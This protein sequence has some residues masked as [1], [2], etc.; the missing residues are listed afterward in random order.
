MAP[1]LLFA[2]TYV[3]AWV[4]YNN[5]ITSICLTWFRYFQ[6]LPEL[7]LSLI[8]SQIVTLLHSTFVT[9]CNHPLGFLPAW[10][11]CLT[12]PSP[13]SRFQL[14]YS[15][16][17]S[18]AAAIFHLCDPCDPVLL[19]CDPLFVPPPRQQCLLMVHRG[20][21]LSIAHMQFKTAKGSCNK[22][23]SNIIPSSSAVSLVHTSSLGPSLDGCMLTRGGWMSV[24]CCLPLLMVSTVKVG[25][26]D[27]WFTI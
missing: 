6:N 10:F 21:D 8:Q 12:T 16:M 23:R 5:N 27:R 15:H 14:L 20:A 11:L 22:F 25:Q 13:A 9:S 1:T 26:V 2:E 7:A 24:G 3:G 19:Y 4:R 18:P 17:A